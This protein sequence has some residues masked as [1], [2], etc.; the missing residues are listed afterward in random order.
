MIAPKPKIEISEDTFKDEEALSSSSSLSHQIFMKSKESL[1]LSGEA[2]QRM[3]L[4]TQKENFM[5]SLLES[6]LTGNSLHLTS[7]KKAEKNI[8]S[9][10]QQ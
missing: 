3:S 8:N 7:K 5:D 2:S 1:S 6:S 10:V 9:F 4:D